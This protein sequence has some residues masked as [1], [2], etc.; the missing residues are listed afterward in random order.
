MIRRL[1]F[2]K[3]PIFGYTFTRASIAE[4]TKAASKKGEIVVPLRGS[5][6]STGEPRIM[7][8]FDLKSGNDSGIIGVAIISKKDVDIL[9]IRKNHS[10]ERR[11]K[12]IEYVNQNL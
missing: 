10:P 1:Y 9:R 3:T 11:A 7:A 4:L 8:S 5:E 2:T 6:I 12:L